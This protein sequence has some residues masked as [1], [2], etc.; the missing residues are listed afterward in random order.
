MLV[1]RFWE[2]LPKMHWMLEWELGLFLALLPNY[3]VALGKLPEFSGLQ[4]LHQDNI[5]I[6]KTLSRPKIQPFSSAIFAPNEGK[7][8]IRERATSAPYLG[9]NWL[10]RRK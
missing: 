7:A 5:G 8:Y 10:E 9:F 3:C 2:Q 1:I 4:F 6:S